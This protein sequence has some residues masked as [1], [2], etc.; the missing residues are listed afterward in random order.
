[1]GTLYEK[2]FRPILFRLE[3]ERAHEL[4]VSGLRFVQAIPGVVP[5]FR[6][7]A[8]RQGWGGAV[9]VFGVAFP[10]RVGLAAGY[11]KN[12]VCWRGLSALGFGHV[13]VGTLTFRPQP[14]NPRPR[15]FRYPAQ[16]AIINRMGF[17]NEGVETVVKNLK[18][19]PKN[20]IIG[21]NIGKNKVTPNENAI[22]DYTKAL[23]NNYEDYFEVKI[24]YQII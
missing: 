16:G 15:L 17:N 18:N 1:M 6:S 7:R 20:L 2:L 9:E 11:D 8:R 13:E 5:T 21:G 14:G 22:D 19:R 3:A 12:A 4:S 10:N 24:N 23:V